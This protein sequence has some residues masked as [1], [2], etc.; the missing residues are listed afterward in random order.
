MSIKDLP[1]NITILGIPYKIE[2]CDI[3]SSVDVHKRESLWGQIDPWTK[4]IR[5]YNGARQPQIIW[6]VIWHELLHG[7]TE[8][9][10]IGFKE[11]DED[12][13]ID[14]LALGL[15]DILIRNKLNFQENT[16]KISKKESK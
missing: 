16:K 15:N 10:N 12:T 3:P 13:I 4:T 7:I 5:I 6:Q 11:D 8:I 9:L 1:E 14:R 2:Y